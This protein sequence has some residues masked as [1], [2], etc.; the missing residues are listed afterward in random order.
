MSRLQGGVPV[1]TAVYMRFSVVGKNCSE[2]LYKNCLNFWALCCGERCL[3][4]TFMNTTLRL[5]DQ[6]YI[7]E[8]SRRG[9]DE[10]PRDKLGR[11]VQIGS[12]TQEIGEKEG[13]TWKGNESK[14]TQT[15][16]WGRD[17]DG[18][19]EMS[20]VEVHSQVLCLPGNIA[21]PWRLGLNILVLGW[22]DQF[23]PFHIY[24]VETSKTRAHLSDFCFFRL[25]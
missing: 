17:Q 19:G 4:V 24:S 13:K 23:T 25:F 14:N 18:E 5:V 11:M 9:K 12:S 2:P 20:Q 10:R 16:K 3:V 8:W 22:A 15:G 21:E 6:R 7:W 1:R